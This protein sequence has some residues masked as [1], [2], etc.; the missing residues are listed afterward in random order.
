MAARVYME[1]SKQSRYALDLAGPA[2]MASLCRA[3]VYLVRGVSI[4]HVD[5]PQLAICAFRDL[6]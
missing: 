6:S 2:Y 3:L 5:V 1:K 4:R